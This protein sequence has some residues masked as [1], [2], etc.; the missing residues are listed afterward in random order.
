[1]IAIRGIRSPLSAAVM[2]VVDDAVV[3]IPRGGMVP[4]ADRYLFAGGLLS[5]ESESIAESLWANC[6][7]VVAMCDQIFTRDP[8]TRVC[9]IGSDAGHAASPDVVYAAA[10]A[11]LHRYVET[12]RLGPAQQLVCVAP[13]LLSDGGMTRRRTDTDAIASR[14][15]A[16]PKGRLL[17]VDEVARVVKFLLY[18]DVM[19][20]T[21]TVIRMHG[22]SSC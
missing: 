19:Y 8:Y 3:E 20:L 14:A 2:A 17:T 5:R 18:E 1:M 12:K 21:G 13:S 4:R 6:G 9:V 10:K 16:H 15:A 11:G 7:E 22:G